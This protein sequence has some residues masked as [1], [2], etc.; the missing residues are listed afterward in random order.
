MEAALTDGGI[1]EAIEDEYEARHPRPEN[2]T[3]LRR[4]PSRQP[5]ASARRFLGAQGVEDFVIQQ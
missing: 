4:P 3:P 5:T 2:V 1:A